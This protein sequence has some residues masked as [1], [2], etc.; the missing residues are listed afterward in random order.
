MSVGG[1]KVMVFDASS[2]SLTH[3]FHVGNARLVRKVMLDQAA[4]APLRT[5]DLYSKVTDHRHMK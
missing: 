5:L 1:G 4:G 3:T 2:W